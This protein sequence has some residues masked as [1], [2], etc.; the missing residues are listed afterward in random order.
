M[1][2]YD[3]AARAGR[4]P[5]D[6]QLHIRGEVSEGLE[7]QLVRLSALLPYEPAVSVMEELARVKVSDTT[8]WRRVQQAGQRVQ[9]LSS[10][11]VVV[12]MG[13]QPAEVGQKQLGATM[14]GAMVHVRGEGWKETKI[15]CVFEVVAAPAPTGAAVPSRL[16]QAGDPL[17]TMTAQHQ[18]YI[19][20]LGGPEAFGVKLEAETTAR[21]W[22]RAVNTSVTA[23]GA[24]WIW[25]LSAQ[26]FATSAHV[27]DWYHAK[28]HLWNAAHVFFSTDEAAAAWVRP[29]SDGLYNGQANALADLLDHSALNLSAPDDLKIL[30]TE[31]GYFRTH[32]ERMQYRD[33]QSAGVP[34]GSGTVESGA[35][36]FKARFCQSGMRWSRAGLQNALPFRAAVM[37]QRFDALWRVI[38]PF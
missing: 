20:H 15:G 31:A 10:E 36:Q 26:Y 4:Y 11:S 38:C 3:G 25:N 21:G 18:T 9:A 24:E 17:Q 29:Q 19:F 30:R 1:Y 12:A 6:E 8:A 2:Y 16:N 37:S 23:D 34:I 27:V 22:A 13:T 7:R 35:K 33:F 14:D 32:H 5:L 28:T